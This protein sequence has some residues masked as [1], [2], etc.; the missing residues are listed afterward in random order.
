MKTTT[1]AI[2]M[3]GMCAAAAA[4]AAAPRVDK[5]DVSMVQDVSTRRVTVTYTLKEAPGIVTVDFQTNATGTAEGPWVSIGVC[6]FANVAGDV[7]RPVRELDVEKYIY[8][9]PD[10]SWP[11]QKI[12]AGN[13]RAEVRA[14]ALNAPPPFMASTMALWP[15]GKRSLRFSQLSGTSCPGAGGTSSVW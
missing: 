3:C 6:N 1:A 11:N 7:N 5:A 12:E 15:P 13:L 8:W 9:Q 10:V 14:W 4:F 2:C